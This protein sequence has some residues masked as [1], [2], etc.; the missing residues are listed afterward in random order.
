M[1]QIVKPLRLEKG[2]SQE[3]LAEIAGLSIRTI[4][5]LENGGTC[6][7]E[8]AKALSAVFDASPDTFLNN[9]PTLDTLQ[10]EKLA[11]VERERRLRRHFRF[12]RHLIKFLI[13]NAGLALI[14]LTFN[15]ETIWF[16]YPLFGW[17]IGLILHAIKTFLRDWEKQLETRLSKKD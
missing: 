17:G 1:E 6:S 16:H 14:N 12:Y 8:T 4:Q 5:R 9:T 2:W 13:V 11:D 15:P 7:L 3:Q 10:R